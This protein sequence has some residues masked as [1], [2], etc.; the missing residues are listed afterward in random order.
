MRPQSHVTNYFGGR[1]YREGKVFVSECEGLPVASQ[2]ESESEAIANLV[3]AL[4]LY[5]DTAVSEGILDEIVRRYGW[6]ATH[7]F[8][9]KEARDRFVIP[10]RVPSQIAASLERSA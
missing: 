3:E 2:G 1:V 5:L 9:S 7:E 4:Q 10:V 6:H 8:P